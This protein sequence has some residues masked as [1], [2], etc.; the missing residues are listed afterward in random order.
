MA[1]RH[2]LFD[3]TEI[4][5]MYPKKKKFVTVNLTYDQISRIQF[6]KFKEFKFFRKVPSEKITIVNSKVKPP[7]VYTKQKEKKFFEEYKEGFKKFV[8]DNNI[9]FI[10]NLDKEEEK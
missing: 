3:K 9:T 4:V 6:D 7:I 8:K 5:L 1:V 2:V 10:N